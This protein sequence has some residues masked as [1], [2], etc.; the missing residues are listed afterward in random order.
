MR[1]NIVLRFGVLSCAEHFEF[2]QPVHK[3][4]RIHMELF[5]IEALGVSLLEEGSEDFPIEKLNSDEQVVLSCDFLLEL[6]G[7]VPGR[8]VEKSNRKVPPNSLPQ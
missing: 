1:A 7:L 5:R 2:V 6:N 3:C 8:R 4:I